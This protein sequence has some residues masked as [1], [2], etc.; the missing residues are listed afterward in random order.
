MAA[1]SSVMPR[2][3]LEVTTPY[4][5]A[6][7]SKPRRAIVRRGF[8]ILRLSEG[9]GQEMRAFCYLLSGGEIA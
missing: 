4:R 6:K 8:F 9:G 2:A 1:Y 5:P 7:F 3:G